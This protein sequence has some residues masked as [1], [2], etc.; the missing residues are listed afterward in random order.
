MEAR[1]AS[2]EK[3]E[4]IIMSFETPELPPVIDGF[5]E[6]D[7]EGLKKFLKGTWTCDG[8]RRSQV[9]ARILPKIECRNPTITEVRVIDTYWS[10]HCRHTTFH[11]VIDDVEIQP[12]YVKDTY[13][14]Y[15]NL[16][17]HIYEG[18]TPKPLCLMDL[19]TIGAKAL[20]KYGKLTDLDESE[21]IKCM[22]RQ[23]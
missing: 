12:E 21:E 8:F 23:D 20:K 16:R 3:P 6:L 5:I 19:G 9:Y 14:N 7:E 1:I 10:D 15:L 4:T 17:N 11:T 2:L 18:R 13:L 22:F